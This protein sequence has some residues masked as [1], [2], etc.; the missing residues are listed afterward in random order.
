LR[1]VSAA[2][3][4]VSDED[5]IAALGLAVSA[6]SMVSLGDI[7]PAQAGVTPW[8]WRI[9]DSLA[10][11][12]ERYTK[13]VSRTARNNDI[14]MD[15]DAFHLEFPD[16]F[17]LC[18]MSRLVGFEVHWTYNL[19]DHLRIRKLRKNGFTTHVF[20]FHHATV[21]NRIAAAYAFLL[22]IPT[23]PLSPSFISGRYVLLP[24]VTVYICM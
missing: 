2:A 10:I 5:V 17:T 8:P 23:P 9:E 4:N 3:Q 14:D 1:I 12:L 6:W 13:W 19:L 21:L 24:Y 20:V 16:Y 11:T 18:S 15:S 22:P 7:F